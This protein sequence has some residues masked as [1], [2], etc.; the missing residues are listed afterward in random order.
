MYKLVVLD[1]DGTLVTSEKK[2][3]QK[4]KDYIKKASELGVKFAIASGRTPYGVLPVAKEINLQ[5]IGGYVLAF[6]GGAC[7]NCETMETLYENYIDK[8][9]L[10]GLYEFG[11]KNNIPLMTYNKDVL[12]TPNEMTK[13]ID[14]ESSLNHLTVHK[15]ENFLDEATFDF[16]KVIFT[17][18]GDKL[19]AFVDEAIETFPQFE[20][21]RSEPFFLEICPK[22]IHKATG[23]KNIIEILGIKQEEVI[24]IGDGYN[25]ITMIEFAGLGVAM[26]N[27]QQAVKDVANYITLS[28]DEDGICKVIEEFIFN[29]K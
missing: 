11:V 8:S 9:E 21:F 23:I 19:G 28:N 6:N 15:T 17:D 13:Y 27:A 26:D 22:G 12:Y 25:D 24:A 29:T 14:M 3:T 1:I 4:T 5:E 16:P 7:L 20:V 2:V 10:K 18:D